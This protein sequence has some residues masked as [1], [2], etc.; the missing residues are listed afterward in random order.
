LQTRLESPVEAMVAELEGVEGGVS[1]FIHLAALVPVKLCEENPERAFALNVDGAVKWLKAASKVG[2]ERF[3]HVSSSHI[4]KATNE[5]VWFEIDRS[6]DAQAVY[7]RSK[8]AAELAMREEAEHLG[9]DLVIAR[10][11][12]VISPTMGPGYLFY[13]L[14]RRAKERDFGPLPGYKNVRDFIHSEAIC[15]SL[16]ALAALRGGQKVYHVCSG[17]PKSVKDLAVE[18]FA[19]H[20]IAESEM[21][22]MFPP[23][24]E[25]ANFMMS[26]PTRI[27]GVQ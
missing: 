5:P 16:E 2:C 22:N 8:A 17:D 10:V 1:A 4:F 12:S 15:K 9:M 24:D 14:H 27:E 11:F 26:H 18:V 7:G 3:V 6:S 19:R 20:G 13:E 25:P 21:A 23:S